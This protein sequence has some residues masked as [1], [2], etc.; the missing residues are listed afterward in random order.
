MT[1]AAT[2][3]DDRDTSGSDELRRPVR[4]VFHSVRGGVGRS[5]AVAV[6]AYHLANRGRAVLVVD[7]DLETPGLSSGLLPLDRL[8]VLGAVDWLAEDSPD[9]SDDVLTGM[10][11]SLPLTRGLPGSVRVVPSYGRDP[12]GSYLTKLRCLHA[13]SLR[14]EGASDSS[15]RLRLCDLVRALEEEVAP[16]VVLIDVR[17]GLS[18][19]SLAPVTDLGAEV[20]LFVT[21]T[22]QTWTGYRLLLRCW[23]QTGTAINLR[24]RL[25]TVAAMVLETG[26]FEY[27]VS[28][29]EGAWNLLRDHTYDLVEAGEEATLYP[30][31]FSFDLTDDFAPHAPIPIY[32]HYGLENLKHLRELEPSLVRSAYSAFLNRIDELVESLVELSRQRQ[33]RE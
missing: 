15:W 30:D 5:T 29:R 18:D 6:T 14:R 16:D 11:V 3:G 8:P 13:G 1:V 27:L 7:L 22:E 26:R 21:D 12:D 23:Q 32:W 31:V 17:S 9:R 28:L 19:L 10:V 4:F 2:V 25:H 20:L 24:E 33:D